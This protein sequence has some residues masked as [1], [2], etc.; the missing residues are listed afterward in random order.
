MYVFV[1]VQAASLSFVNS[2]RLF[3]NSSIQ[4]PLD[5]LLVISRHLS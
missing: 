2:Q 5:S 3:N 1:N 4:Q